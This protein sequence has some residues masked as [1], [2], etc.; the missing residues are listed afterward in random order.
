MHHVT[1]L[2]LFIILFSLIWAHLPDP[3]TGKLV[4]PS[5]GYGY[6]YIELY[7]RRAAKTWQV[8]VGLSLGT[9]AGESRLLSLHWLVLTFSVLFHSEWASIPDRGLPLLCPVGQDPEQS[10]KK[11]RGIIFLTEGKY[12]CHWEYVFWLFSVVSKLFLFIGSVE[13]TALDMILLALIHL[14][15]HC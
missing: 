6:K 14:L 15:P 13:A 11:R 3:T 12:P 2:K 7:L 5:T 9:Q 1:L 4:S 8:S 10:W